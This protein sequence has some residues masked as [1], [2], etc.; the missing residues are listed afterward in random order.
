MSSKTD[1]SPTA[2][3]S[4]HAGS[5]AFATA[6]EALYMKQGSVTGVPLVFILSIF[7]FL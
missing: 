5:L 2:N 1:V 4:A 6:T 7:H 3:G